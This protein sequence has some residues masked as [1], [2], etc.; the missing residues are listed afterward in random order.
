[1]IRGCGVTQLGSVLG[2]Q[3]TPT[4]VALEFSVHSILLVLG[5]GYK[6]KGP[7][8]EF[9]VAGPEGD[10]QGRTLRRVVSPLGGR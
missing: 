8:H 10:H 4:A 9:I 7:A 5:A 2:R 3:G 6:R 1:M